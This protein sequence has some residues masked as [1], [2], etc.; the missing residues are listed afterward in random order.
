MVTEW[1]PINL[2]IYK[3]NAA[4][5]AYEGQLLAIGGRYDYLV[6]KLWQRE[7][8]NYLKHFLMN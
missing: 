7:S 2:Q 4:G 5:S 8:V 6:Q 3:A 1:S